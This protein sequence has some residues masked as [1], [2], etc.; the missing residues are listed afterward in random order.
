MKRLIDRKLREWKDSSRRKPLIVRGARQVGKTYSVV[1]FGEQS[2]ENLATVDLERNRDL[3]RIFTPD[4]NPKRI[5]SELEIFLDVKLTPGKTLLF[6]DEIQSCPEA[7]MALKYFHEEQPELHVVAAGSLLEFALRETSFPVGRIQFLDMHPMS[8]PEYLW[9]LGKDEA[10]KII[11]SQPKELAESTHEL[12]LKELRNYF[13]VGGMP[14]SVRVY[15]ETGS[16]REVF[17]VH[18]DLV[19]SFRH[20]FSK[21]SPRVDSQCLDGVLT[22]VARNVGTQV[23]YA[24]L[25]EG[26][27]YQTI[28]RAF[29][30]LRMARLITKVPSS[31]PKGLPLSATASQRKFK[32]TMVDIG[33]WQHLCGIKV[34]TEYSKSNLLDIYRGAMAEQFVGQEML[35]PQRSQLYYWARSAKS[36]TAEVDY[37]GTVGDTIIPVEVKSGPA[38]KLRS[39]H[40]LLE[41]FPQIPRGV[42]LS[43]RIYSE[44]PSQ[45]LVFIPIYYA[46]SATGGSA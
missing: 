16:L 17:G 40:L 43:T 42:V 15:V 4:L 34:D 35:I 20:D 23:T 32:A 41:S 6:L 22:G 2:F 24:R 36:S 14:E 31:N 8:F 3:H 1:Q 5:M 33:L 45:R 10:A 39:L 19:E 26:F 44:L 18:R 7:I 37:L 28:K 12:L 21:Y 25:M 38:G 29:N 46:Y 9:G 13:F 30:A 11:A 27:S